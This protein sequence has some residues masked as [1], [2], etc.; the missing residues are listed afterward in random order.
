MSTVQ[1][2][3][4]P[5]ASASSGFSV[6]A[7]CAL[8]RAHFVRMF[9]PRFAVMV[10]NGT[11]LQTVRP[12]PKRMPKAG[13]TISLRCWT[14]LP[15]RSKQRV[16]RESIIAAVRTIEIDSYAITIDGVR[17]H[18]QGEEEFA[19]ADGFNSPGE[20]T[21]WFRDTHGLPFVGI[22]LYWHNVPDEPQAR[23]TPKI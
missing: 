7:G 8:P 21:A 16:L 9:K 18:H 17:L 15:Y 6:P 22:V 5:A 12:R 20:M 2:I 1:P 23:S 11:K 19:M 13:D 14:G 3:L 4:A 10:E